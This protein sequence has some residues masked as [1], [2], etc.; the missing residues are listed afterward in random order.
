MTAQ[1]ELA[2]VRKAFNEG[3]PNAFWAVDGIDLSLPSG[4]ITV[5][6]GPSGSGKTTMLTL[7]GC[8]ARPTEGRVRLDGRDISGLPEPFLAALRR[9][10]FGF[11]FQRFNLIRG[12]P[13]LDN[14]MLPAYPLGS[15][16]GPL[17][18]RAFELLERL[19]LAHRAEARVESLSG[20]EAQRTA[21]ARALIN[22]PPV[23]I[24]DEPTANL[25]SALSSAFLEIVAG[26]REEG[27]TLL[28]SSHDPLVREA[29]VV[30]RV[31]EL[32]DG[33]VIA[34]RTRPAATR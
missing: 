11:V 19:G 24:A 34:D 14:V 18:R 21:I 25:D 9:R 13:V 5:V 7:V 28:L 31:I 4:G 22:D 20:G 26:L 16:R 1:V 2:G 10:T 33:R 12:L 23:L 30:D 17:R 29:A 6:A 15:P 27:R 8:L 3:Q 32:R